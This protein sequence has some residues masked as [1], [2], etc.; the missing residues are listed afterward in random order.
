VP[1]LSSIDLVLVPQ[2]AEYQ[3]VCRGLSRVQDSKP[4]VI[5]VPVGINPLR[6]FLSTLSL[7]PNQ[8]VLLM[9]LCGSLNPQLQVGD[10]VVYAECIYQGD[11]RKCD[12]TLT[13]EI[14]S[15]LSNKVKF[16]K[17]L[18]SDR[19]ISLA[20]EKQDLFAKTGAD[21]VDMEGFAALEF[22]QHIGVNLAMVRV[23][24][25]DCRY[26]IPNLA[27]AISSDG[28]L[29]PLPLAWEFLRQPVPALRLIRGS[30][31]GLKILEQI[32][33]LLFNLSA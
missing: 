10:A 25:D 30:L 11:L 31:A 8:R 23:V 24:S 4:Q 26:D 7:Q 16:V 13:A 21:V 20:T 19:V 22:C 17:G 33:T 3:A 29:Q 9:G 12:R 27:S 18:T 15:C 6:H 1:K 14:N 5:A 2:G 32:T 28:S